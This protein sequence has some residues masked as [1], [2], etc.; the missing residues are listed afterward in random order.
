[1]YTREKTVLVGVPV[2][3]LR[4]HAAR[5]LRTDASSG[6]IYAGTFAAGLPLVWERSFWAGEHPL[7]YPPGVM[8]DPQSLPFHPQEFAEA[9]NAEWLGF[10]YTGAPH[11]DEF[12]PNTLPVCGFTMY[13]PGQEPPP[14][15]QSPNGRAAQEPMPDAPDE[16]APRPKKRWFSRK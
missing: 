1:M 12:D 2:P 10:R 6:L 9:A 11:A 5:V 14:P 13:V 7:I 16:Q 3:D 4:A 8:P 15:N